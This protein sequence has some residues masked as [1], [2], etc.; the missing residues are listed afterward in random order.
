MS[1][2]VTKRMQTEEQNHVLKEKAEKAVQS[3]ANMV[4]RMSHDL[5]TSLVGVMSPAEVCDMIV[6]KC[7]FD[8]SSVFACL[9]MSMG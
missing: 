5:R 6:Y 9:C 8:M 3:M 2:D 4:V 1:T 7:F